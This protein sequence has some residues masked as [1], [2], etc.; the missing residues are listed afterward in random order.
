MQNYRPVNWEAV[1]EREEEL[2][3]SLRVA[4]VPVGDAPRMGA[5]RED[6]SVTVV[7]FAD[8][9]CPYCE[10]SAQVWRDLVAL[11]E[12]A[13][14]RVVFKHF[15]IQEGAERVAAASVLAHGIG[16]FWSF[17]DAAFEGAL[18]DDGIQQLLENLGWSGDLEEELAGAKAVVQADR[19]FGRGVGVD[20]TPTIFI[21]G[22]HL[23]GVWSVEELAPLIEDQMEL[24][25]TLRELTGNGGEE[26]YRDLVEINGD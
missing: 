23:M 25:E 7:V 1:E 3:Q 16:E 15:P 13:G 21:N 20:G 8:F 6:S 10:E 26:L 17:H 19:E 24:G 11:Y 2:E 9:E 22:I 18:E 5:S 4:Y 12:S 14:L